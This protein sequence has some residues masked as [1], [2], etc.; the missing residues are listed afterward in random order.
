MSEWQINV[1]VGGVFLIAYGVFR[2]VD[3]LKRVANL[4]EGVRDNTLD[5]EKVRRDRGW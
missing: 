2:I 3:L 5:V 4:L 1:I